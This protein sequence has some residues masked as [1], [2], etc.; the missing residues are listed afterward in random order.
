MNKKIRSI[1]ITLCV[2]LVA[3]ISLAVVMKVLENMDTEDGT[4]STKKLTNYTVGDVASV[5][6]ELSNGEY[7]YITEDA[8]SSVGSSTVQYKVTF[9]GIYEGLEYDTTL[10][11]QVV[12]YA[13]QLTAQRDMGVQDKDNLSLFG[14][15]TPA[16]V[17]TI[18][19]D[20]GTE[21][22]LY[23]GNAASGGLGYYCLVDGDDHVYVIAPVRGETF[24]KTPNDMRVKQFVLPT[25]LE[26][27]D[28]V[29]WKFGKNDYIR[30]YRD[31][32]SSVFNPYLN[33]YI[34]SPWTMPLPANGDDLNHLFENMTSLT[35]NEYITPKTDGSDVVME[36]Y[37]LADPWGYFKI[38]CIDGTVYE[39]SFGDYS[40][41][42]EYYCY[43][44]DHST[45]QIYTVPYARATHFADY[46]PIDVTSPYLILANLNDIESIVA[47]YDGKISDF[48]HKRVSTGTDENGEVVYSHTYMLEGMTYENKKMELLYRNVIGMKVQNQYKGYS[49]EAEA[50]L[51]LT[52]TAFDVD[53]EPK[54][55][56]FYKINDDLCVAEIDGHKDIMVSV[57]DVQDYINAIDMVKNGQSPPYKF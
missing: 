40:D 33:Y 30:I 26:K 16:S 48:V 50:M 57:R 3:L 6:V 45:N 17:I 55:I 13:S 34:D 44:R 19:L 24:L 11:K 43:M 54:V 37:G 53:T 21:K 5:K 38:T 29:E 7:Y 32:E 28:K 22:K 46:T 15:D 10:S 31:L 42:I 2:G 9:N 18:L 14:L 4:V 51:T 12:S 23:I 35:V 1:L 8:S 52:I 20:D 36:E 47:Q 56:S 25:S 39:F 27:I 41:D 49:H